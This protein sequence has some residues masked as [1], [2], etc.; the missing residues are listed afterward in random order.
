MLGAGYDVLRTGLLKTSFGS[1]GGPGETTEE[2]RPGDNPQSHVPPCTDVIRHC[3]SNA[4]AARGFEPSA[5]NIAEL[6]G[7]TDPCAQL[8][9]KQGEVVYT[10]IYTASPGSPGREC[11]LLIDPKH[12]MTPGY[13]TDDVSQVRL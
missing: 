11:M 1:L 4:T 2:Y 6:N 7:W 5:S 10:A 13:N 3:K 8:L 9:G 12:S